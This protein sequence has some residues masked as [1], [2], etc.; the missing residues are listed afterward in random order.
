M[1][2]P[3]T[4]ESATV[5]MMDMIAMLIGMKAATSAPK[6]RI[7]TIMAAGSPNF[8]SPLVRS[9]SESSVKSWSRVLDPVIVT[10]KSA[11]GVGGRPPRRARPRSR[12]RVVGEDQRHH[13]RVPVL[14][15]GQLVG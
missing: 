3:S 14:G 11:C 10:S 1:N 6:T 13:H 12:F 9:D 5:T 15:D 8:S 7:S 4:E 2:W